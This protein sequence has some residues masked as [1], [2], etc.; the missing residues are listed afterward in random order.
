MGKLWEPGDRYYQSRRNRRRGFPLEREAKR[1]RWKKLLWQAGASLLVFLLVWGIFQ[2]NSPLV[3]PVHGKIRDW[4]TRDYDIQPVLKLFS[5]MGLW[6]DAIEKAAFETV[7]IPENP[8]PLTVPVSGQVTEQFGLL[9]ATDK[10]QTFNDGITIAAPEG[11]PIKAALAG[12]VTRLANEEEKGRIVEITADNGY[13]TTYAHCKEILVNLNDKI[14]AGQVIARVGKTGNA[15]HPQ[16]YF[17][18]MISGEA[19]DPTKFFIPA[20]DKT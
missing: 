9:T 5:D 6:G 18:I 20:A 8:G 3:Q 2:F 13:I 11:T 14:A 7:K 10:S 17:R 16:L 4:F 1:P 19:L 12:M 15:A